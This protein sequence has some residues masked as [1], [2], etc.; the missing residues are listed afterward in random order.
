MQPG[1]LP[2]K[3]FYGQWKKMRKRRVWLL[4]GGSGS[5]EGH[6]LVEMGRSSGR[7]GAAF[8]EMCVDPLKPNPQAFVAHPCSPVQLEP[9]EA[10]LPA[11]LLRRSRGLCLRIQRGEPHLQRPGGAD[12]PGKGTS[13]W[14]R[15]QMSV[16]LPPWPSSLDV[17]ALSE[18]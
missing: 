6:C 18:V 13:V 9:L 2:W 8:Q 14:D 1:G 3:V 12:T 15:A 10:S 17:V 7:N 11:E 5:A 4:L 16:P